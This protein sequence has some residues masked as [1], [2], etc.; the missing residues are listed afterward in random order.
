MNAETEV[1][2][3]SPKRRGR[4]PQSA[5]PRI[6]ERYKAGAT[7]SAIAREFDCTPSAISYIVRKA[8]A[9]GVTAGS[10]M[11]TPVIDTPAA[12]TAAP[13]AV[14]TPA[15]KPEAKAEKA[16]TPRPAR[17]S[18][19][20]AVS[21]ADAMT[22]QPVAQ[23]T[24]AVMEPVAA[25]AAPAAAVPPP[26]ATAPAAPAQPAPAQPAPVQD[27][28]A[29][30]AQ[31]A[32]PASLPQRELPLQHDSGR[33]G[34]GAPRRFE[35]RD[36][37]PPREPREGRHDRQEFRGDRE[38]R[39]GDRGEGRGGE[40][41]GENRGQQGGDQ[42]RP[43]SG[44]VPRYPQGGQPGPQRNERFGRDRLEGG[45]RPPRDFERDRTPAPDRAA[46]DPGIAE[47]PTETVYPYRQQQRNPAR[48]EAAETPTQPADER[49]D[50]AAKVSA[51]AY[52]AWKNQSG[53]VQGLT[54]ALHELR[55]VIARME[56]EISASRKE[57]QRPIPFPSYRS[58]L[59]PPQQP[60]G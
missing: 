55:K 16:D 51:E 21:K 41:G 13:A 43:L 30:T 14:E 39:G 29:Q 54:D 37:R 24:P 6:L 22:E 10:D 15:S 42:R 12:P 40:R 1:D 52:R 31:E 44:G 7:L 26:V 5:W 18:P 59:P 34:E 35:G 38:A 47:G 53:G 23:E 46:A 20:Q 28:P 45:N 2:A 48:L 57:E 36:N 32:A 19:R 56:I 58:H 50:A 17:R 3:E 25:A 33:A 49:M 4:I 9:A 11:D 27:G 8:E 60:R